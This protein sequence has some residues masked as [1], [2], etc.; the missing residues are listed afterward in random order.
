VSSYPIL[1][2][3]AHKE[4]ETGKTKDESDAGYW[5]L[6]AGYW[7]AYRSAAKVGCWAVKNALLNV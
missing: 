7:P 6:D 5:M 1:A 2:G 4:I 3:L